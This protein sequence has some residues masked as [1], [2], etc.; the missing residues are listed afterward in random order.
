MLSS[1]KFR[2]QI[3]NKLSNYFDEDE[4][5]YFDNIRAQFHLKALKDDHDFQEKIVKSLSKEILNRFADD[6]LNIS[7]FKEECNQKVSDTNI[8]ITQEVSLA[9][10]R[11]LSVK[12]E[13]LE[14]INNNKENERNEIKNVLK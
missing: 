14:I 2:I 1:H 4:G 6:I 8:R 12:Q 10:E 7:N 13:L 5:V 11:I 3:G 9:N